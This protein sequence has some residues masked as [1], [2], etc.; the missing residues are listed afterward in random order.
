MSHVINTPGNK[1]IR[2]TKVIAETDTQGD[3]TVSGFYQRLATG[4]RFYGLDGELFACLI[5]NRHGV[6]FV[7]ANATV[8]GTWFMQSTTTHTERMLGIEGLGYRA[9]KELEQKIVDEL[10]IYTANTTLA[11]HGVTFE[12][13]VG[14]ANQEPTS[15]DA[16]Q[17]FYRA[18]LTA[19]LQGIEDDGYF[20]ATRLGR[21]MLAGQ[22]YDTV[23]G[24]WVK[25]PVASAA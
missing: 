8:K 6:F 10:D 25:L 23:G 16:L 18:G 21:N 7:T 19:D 2:A 11:K 24:K 12:Q 22:G 9:Q 13:F 1:W 14:M 4:I 20:L 3:A 15:E 17:V 5:T